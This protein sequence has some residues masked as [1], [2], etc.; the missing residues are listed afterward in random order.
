MEKF[1]ARHADKM[2]QA[3]LLTGAKAAALADFKKYLE[4]APKNAPAW[5]EA[6]QQVARLG[7]STKKQSCMEKPIS[8]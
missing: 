3:E 6:T 2:A 4:I 5:H 8:T 7:S 1:I